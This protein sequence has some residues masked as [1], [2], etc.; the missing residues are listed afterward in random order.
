[1]TATGGTKKCGSILNLAVIIFAQATVFDTFQGS[2]PLDKGTSQK[3]QNEE[4]VDST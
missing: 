1:M 4:R 2:S 3:L